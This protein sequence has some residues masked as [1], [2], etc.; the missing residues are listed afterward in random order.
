MTKPT[1]AHTLILVAITLLACSCAKTINGCKIERATDCRGAILVGADLSHFD[2]G[3]ADLTDAD[4][5]DADLSGAIL[6]NADLSGADLSGA[7]LSG[8]DL[9][10]ANL[11]GAMLRLAKYNTNTKWTLGFDPEAAGAVLVD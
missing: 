10:N 11:V 1:A 2:L 3:G 8:A 9:T 5:S 4:L 6:W 7:D